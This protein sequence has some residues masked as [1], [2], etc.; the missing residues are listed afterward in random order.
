MGLPHILPR[1]AAD[2]DFGHNLVVTMP[3]GEIGMI[4]ASPGLGRGT[5]LG[6]ILR[7]RGSL[8]EEVR[9]GP[10]G[11]FA[12]LCPLVTEEPKSFGPQRPGTEQRAVSIHISLAIF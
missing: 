11:H 1:L 2:I 6:T 5:G 7:V 9:Y 10:T 12:L 3:D 8:W 4:I